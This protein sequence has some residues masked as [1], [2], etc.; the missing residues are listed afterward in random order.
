V[1]IERDT[2]DIHVSKWLCSYL[3]LAIQVQDAKEGDGVKQVVLQS[4]AKVGL[5]LEKPED[6]KINI[7]TSGVMSEKVTEK[8]LTVRVSNSIQIFGDDSN[9]PKFDSG[10]N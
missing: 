10:G 6:L 7:L 9:K 4:G 5:C 1:L 2:N 3:C 8:F